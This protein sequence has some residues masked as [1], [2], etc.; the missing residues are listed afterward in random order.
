MSKLSV[1]S[2]N[3]RKPY[4]LAQKCQCRYIRSTDNSISASLI[5]FPNIKQTHPK[6]QMYTMLTINS[7]LNIT[8]YFDR[9]G[10]T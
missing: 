10:M 8:P 1:K 2:L 4:H 6:L 5:F 7:K 3:D 9:A